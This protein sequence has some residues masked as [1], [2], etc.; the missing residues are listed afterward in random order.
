MGDEFLC[1]ATA[2]D[3]Y[4]G[5][6]IN[7]GSVIVGNSAPSIG[8][9]SIAVANNPDYSFTSKLDVQCLAENIFDLNNDSH[10]SMQVDN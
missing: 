9:V 10:I 3:E 7:A 2:L 8:S 1:T 6:G 5:E 4:G